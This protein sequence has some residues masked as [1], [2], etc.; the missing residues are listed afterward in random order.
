MVPRTHLDTPLGFLLTPFFYCPFSFA[1]PFLDSSPSSCLSQC[2]AAA[3]FSGI[4][5]IRYGTY[6]VGCLVQARKGGH[7]NCMTQSQCC[8]CN[9]RPKFASSV[10]PSLDN[11]RMDTEEMPVRAATL[12]EIYTLAP[13]GI[14]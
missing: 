10:L 9:A 3:S 11:T 5:I 2:H 13:V 14:F 6:L 8:R 4:N 12:S 1:P 7:T